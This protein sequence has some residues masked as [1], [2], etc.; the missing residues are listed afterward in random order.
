VHQGPDVGL[1][2][3]AVLLDEGP[4]NPAVARVF[5]AMRRAEGGKKA[6]AAAFDAADPLP[7]DRGSY[8]DVGSLT[9]PPCGEGVQWQVLKQHGHVSKAEIAALRKLYPMNA[10]PVQPLDGRVVEVS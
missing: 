2:V 5:D 3:V 9:T 7:A 10:R 1:A 4:A 8:R 6:P